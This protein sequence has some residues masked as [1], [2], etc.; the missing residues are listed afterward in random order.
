MNDL[1]AIYKEMPVTALRRYFRRLK[2]GWRVLAGKDSHD[3]AGYRNGRKY[4]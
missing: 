1:I 2:N 4:G 3:Y